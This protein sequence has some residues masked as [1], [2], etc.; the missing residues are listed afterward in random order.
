MAHDTAKVGC[1]L[2]SGRRSGELL[3]TKRRGR[4]RVEFEPAR[5]P[6]V[7]RAAREVD[8]EPQQ[9]AGA[10]GAGLP[11]AQLASVETASYRRRR[12][13]RR[14]EAYDR[15]VAPEVLRRRGSSA[16]QVVHDQVDQLD[17]DER[18]DE[19]AEPVDPEVATEQ[20]ARLPASNSSAPRSW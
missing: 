2:G 20:Q 16:E 15:A 7:E 4:R 3:R 18:R 14:G 13:A 10:A 12:D 9:R 19:A 17:A 5:D 11:V 6:P 1:Q 8:A